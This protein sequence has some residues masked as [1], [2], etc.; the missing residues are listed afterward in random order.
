M[1]TLGRPLAETR[2][3][4]PLPAASR[5]AR[6][7]SSR[8]RRPAVLA[9][10]L[11]ALGLAAAGCTVPT[12]T[13]DLTRDMSVPIGSSSQ[14][15]LYGLD[16]AL[17]PGAIGSACTRNSDCTLT[18]GTPTCWATNVLADPGNLP[19]PGG[20]CTTPC[21]VDADC[22]SQGTCQTVSQ[23]AKYCLAS[24]FTANVCRYQQ[25]Y[26]CFILGPAK[27]YC[28]PSNR[29]SCNPTQIDPGT[30]NGTC[31]GS[32]PP[33]A[34][35]RRAFE[36][37]GE[38]LNTCT[39]GSGTCPAVG[40]IIQHCV[41]VNQTY[42]AAGQ[43]TRDKFKG[44]ACFPLSATPKQIGESCTYLD[45]CADG[46]QCNNGPSGDKKCHPLC[47]VGAPGSCPTGQTCNDSFAAGR[48][49]PGLCF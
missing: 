20:Y 34:C 11:G 9:L 8:L 24:C 45:E 42:D 48:G 28:Y 25:R 36:D 43:P 13:I 4:G 29:L 2:A 32:S 35:I 17:T 33:A 6:W 39:P 19:T 47:T 3:A 15:D 30:G 46:L 7:A 5:S 10:V 49:N 14:L 1:K 12:Q 16:L 23:G 18:G 31:P 41:Y 38:C 44:T 22:G 21:S 26:A 27:G 37:L 40:G